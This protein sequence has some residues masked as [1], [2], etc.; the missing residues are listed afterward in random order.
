MKKMF[1]IA[2]AFAAV[3]ALSLAGPAQADAGIKKLAKQDCK[4][5]R[6]TDR[7]EFIAMF[8]GT[9]KAALN[10]CV[11]YEKREARRDCKEDLREEPAEFNAQYGGTDKAAMK[12]CITNK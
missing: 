5:E 7:A 11:K 4:V 8:G 6:A 1:A 3:L 9:G 10:R 12:R 2:A